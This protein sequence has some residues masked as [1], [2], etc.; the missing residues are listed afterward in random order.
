MP[1]GLLYHDQGTGVCC[2]R[3][4]LS[5]LLSWKPRGGG[6]WLGRGRWGSE[7]EEEGQEEREG[8]EDALGLLCGT[9]R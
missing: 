2:D 6:W 1:Y 4:K 3:V 5:F 7:E 8:E 9:C